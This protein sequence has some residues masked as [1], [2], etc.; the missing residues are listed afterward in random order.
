MTDIE[1]KIQF[2]SESSGGKGSCKGTAFHMT[3]GFQRGR[4]RG[5]QEPPHRCRCVRRGS[6]QHGGVWGWGSWRDPVVFT[7]GCSWLPRICGSRGCVQVHP[8][9][10]GNT[11]SVF[12]AG[13]QLGRQKD[14][15]CAWG[16]LLLAGVRPAPQNRHCQHGSLPA[17]DQQSIW[18]CSVAASGSR[19][20]VQ[21]IWPGTRPSVS[22][23]KS[24]S[25]SQ[26]VYL[27]WAN[28]SD[29]LPVFLFAHVK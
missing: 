18:L 7:T 25:R 19:E 16:L 5:D 3:E 1:F 17:G 24:S 29:S 9:P 14:P 15:G 26:A 23:D 13:E 28:I 2:M 10:A 27:P 8:S 4:A 12:T 11:G 6:S 21:Q 20:T 22:K